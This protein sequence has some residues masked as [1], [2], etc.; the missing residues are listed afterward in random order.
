MKRTN[1]LGDDRE[2]DR[3]ER[4]S[5]YYL[6]GTIMEQKTILCTHCRS[7]FTD[8]ETMN[9]TDCPACHTRGVPANLL[10]KHTVTLTDHEWRII[11]IWADN[12]TK[13]IKDDNGSAAECMRGIRSCVKK[14]CP[15]FPSMTLLDDIQDAANATGIKMEYH[16][17]GEK[18]EIEPEKKH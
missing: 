2:L 9:A 7:E 1:K 4:R 14:Q 5:T 3:A 12:W 10:E 16:S 11:F 8:D 15:D 6:L 13:N 18:T 17:G